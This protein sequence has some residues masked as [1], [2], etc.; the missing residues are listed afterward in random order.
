[1]DDAT[2]PAIDAGDPFSDWLFEPV[3]NG[4]IINQGAYGGTS[5]A[6]LSNE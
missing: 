4:L 3:S 6:S 2:S 1:M 5:Q